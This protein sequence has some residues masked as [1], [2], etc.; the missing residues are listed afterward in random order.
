MGQPSWSVTAST[1]RPPW[2][3][4]GSAWRSP[5]GAP[6]PRRKRPDVVLTVDRVA[7]LA[8]AIMI[9][10]RSRRIALVAVLFGMGLSLV[11]MGV[12]AIGLLA[13][14][15]G[16]IVQELIDVASIGIALIAVLPGRSHIPRM[17]P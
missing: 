2:Q 7:A 6:R 10:R 16:A 11:A 8:D 4:Q 5:F 14:A 9:A 15:A 3:R 12:A 1:M 13:P 17:S